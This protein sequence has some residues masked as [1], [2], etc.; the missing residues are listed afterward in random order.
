MSDFLTSL[1]ARAVA[2]VPAVRPA[3]RSLYEPPI[4]VESTGLAPVTASMPV[5]ATPTAPWNP[6]QS[7]PLV[8][9]PEIET[10][11]H[12]REYLTPLHPSASPDVK[13]LNVA[14]GLTSDPPPPIH[15]IPA[16]PAPRD[17]MVR[18][19]KCSQ[20]ATAAAAEL[21]PALPSPPAVR[22]VVVPAASPLPHPG[23]EMIRPGRKPADE[24]PSDSSRPA[25]PVPV[26]RP[27][28]LTPAP[29]EA[30]LP[31]PPQP[32]RSPLLAAAIPVLPDKSPSRPVAL[33]APPSAPE[34]TIT[35]GRVE[36]RAAAPA[37]Q[38]PVSA[39]GDTGPHLSLDAFLRRN[40]SQ[41]A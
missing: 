40:A 20:P 30:L 27:A 17:P 15:A 39:L 16:P 41:P 28:Q 2:P 22:P 11:P 25:A 13:S 36:I 7:Q 6:A 21:A 9:A 12:V 29:A 34:V 14:S 37:A 33:R 8:R 26:L 18:K 24:T 31:P 10:T 4:A 3:I 38:V 23:G 35:I 32:Q 19:S 5:E 1:A